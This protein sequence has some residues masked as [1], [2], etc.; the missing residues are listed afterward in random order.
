MTWTTKAGNGTPEM[1]RRWAWLVVALGWLACGGRSALR[2]SLAGEEGDDG[3]WSGSDGGKGGS[4]NTQSGGRTSS[5]GTSSGGISGKGGAVTPSGG[6]TV[7][8]GGSG[9]TVRGGSGGTTVRGGSGG[10]VRGGSGGSG[11]GGRGGSGGTTVRGGSGGSGS[12]GTAGRGGSGSGGRAGA[13]GATI[14]IPDAAPV[15]SDARE[16][17]PVE[18][19]TPVIDPNTGYTVVSTGK[20]TMSGYVTG[21]AQGSGSTI[22]LTYNE[23]SFCAAGNVGASTTWN[24]WAVSGFQVN[25]PQAQDTVPLQPLALNGSEMAVTYTNKTGTKLE[26]Q[27]WDGTT[28][29]YWCYYLPPS[30]NPTTITAKF[31]ELNTKCWDESGT[32]FTS[33]TSITA[34]QLLVPGDETRSTPFDY[35]FLGLTVN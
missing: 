21:T 22:G 35:C 15:R 7:A 5:G 20:I 12:G 13:G 31:S 10:T 27:L 32:S 17:A 6:T 34:V 26:L 3:G 9:G 23:N 11:S 33:G 18:V 24:S 28:G 14:V 16:V 29:R 19:G 2:A 4:V 30:A 1:I 25:Q 8:Q